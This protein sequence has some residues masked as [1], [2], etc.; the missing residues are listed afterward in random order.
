MITFAKLA[1]K[2]FSLIHL[3]KNLDFKDFF[4]IFINL[5]KLQIIIFRELI[6]KNDKR[7][8]ELSEKYQA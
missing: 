4:I 5:F 3:M 1:F 7:E 6:L 8:L 2:K